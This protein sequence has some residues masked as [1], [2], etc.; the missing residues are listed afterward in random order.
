MG[1]ETLD[2]T[3]LAALICNSPDGLVD[4]MSKIDVYFVLESAGKQGD[5]ECENRFAYTLDT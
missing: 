3:Q 4:R 5:L 1:I 2:E